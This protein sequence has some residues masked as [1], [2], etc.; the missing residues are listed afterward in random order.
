MQSILML[1]QDCGMD[2]LKETLRW[3]FNVC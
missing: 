2:R 1:N 3:Q